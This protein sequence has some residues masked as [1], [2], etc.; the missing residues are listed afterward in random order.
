MFRQRPTRAMHMDHTADVFHRNVYV[1]FCLKQ[2]DRPMSAEQRTTVIRHILV[3]HGAFYQLLGVVVM[4]DHCHLVMMPQPPYDVQR[5][6]GGIKRATTAELRRGS[7]AC[8]AFWQRSWHE[9]ILQH[10]GQIEPT[11]QYLRMNPRRAGLGE[12]LHD[13]T[14]WIHPDHRKSDEISAYDHLDPFLGKRQTPSS[15]PR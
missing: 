9:R 11:L 7:V 10:D 2:R 1:T 13:G 4:P 14:L 5:I 6:I 3:G 12:W 15:E 8:G